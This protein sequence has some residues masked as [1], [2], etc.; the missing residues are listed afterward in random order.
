MMC[1]VFKRQIADAEATPLF[2]N[3]KTAE[4]EYRTKKSEYGLLF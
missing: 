1:C 4:S 2:L 3:P